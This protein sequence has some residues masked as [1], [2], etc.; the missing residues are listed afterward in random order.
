MGK[1]SGSLGVLFMFS[2]LAMTNNSDPSSLRLE[3]KLL[4]HQLSSLFNSSEGTAEENDI[5]LA[6][7][8]AEIFFY[9]V[10]HFLGTL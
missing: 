3:K 2:L 1:S 5:F 10:Q 4:D 9:S 6:T 8:S 7:D